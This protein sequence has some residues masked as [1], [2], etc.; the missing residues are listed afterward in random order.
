MEKQVIIKRKM[1]DK[2][3]LISFAFVL[4]LS[5]TNSIIFFNIQQNFITLDVWVNFLTYFI[6]FIF[7]VLYF[8]F[9]KIWLVSIGTSLLCINAYINCI[10]GIFNLFSVPLMIRV[11][12]IIEF[13]LFI[14][15]LIL[16]FF[17]V[18]YYIKGDKHV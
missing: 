17:S 10:N 9:R 16:D 15:T 11:F 13:I 12:C 4:I 3:F 6:I 14:L 8:V 7:L 18:L 2:V 5:L 1:I